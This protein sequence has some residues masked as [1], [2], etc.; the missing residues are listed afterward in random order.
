[1]ILT[2]TQE[3]QISSLNLQISCLT[4][5]CGSK[6]FISTAQTRPSKFML[7]NL[8]CKTTPLPGIVN[9]RLSK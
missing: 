9:S 3:G 7:E 2:Q 1:M 5:L 6:H 4:V 8:T